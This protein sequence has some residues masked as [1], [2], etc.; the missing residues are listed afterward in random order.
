[1]FGTAAVPV[2]ALFLVLRVPSQSKHRQVF[3]AAELLT[4]TGVSEQNK[5]HGFFANSWPPN[6]GS[7]PQLDTAVV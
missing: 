5:V 6:R 2:T 3:S 7:P 1:M 4:Y